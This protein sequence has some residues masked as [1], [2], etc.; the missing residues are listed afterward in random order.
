MS[1]YRSP[2]LKTVRI[3]EENNILNASHEIITVIPVETG[4]TY[5]YEEAGE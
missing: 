2:T 3:S 5:Y 1:N 4:F